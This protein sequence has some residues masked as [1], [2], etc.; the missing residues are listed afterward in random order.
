MLVGMILTY[1]IRDFIV[2]R[3]RQQHHAGIILA[4]HR[5]MILRE[6]INALDHILRETDANEWIGQTRWL[7]D[8]KR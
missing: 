4:Y 7:N 5:R 2:L 8:W 6:M 1:N 3:Q